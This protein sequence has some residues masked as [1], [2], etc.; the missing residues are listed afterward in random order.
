M[1]SPWRPNSDDF[2]LPAEEAMHGCMI[3]RAAYIN[4]LLFAKADSTFFGCRDPNLSRRQLLERYISY[5]EH[6][7]SE[8]GPKKLTIRK[9]QVGPSTS[10]LLKPIHTVMNGLKNVN[11]YK[12]DLNDIYV[13]IVQRGVPNPSCREVVSNNK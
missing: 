2:T 11:K 7:Q 12:K 1:T 5:C 3:G 8:N 10:I 9:T 6:A 4:P 13:A